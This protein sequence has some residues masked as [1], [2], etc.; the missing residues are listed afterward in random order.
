M[1]TPAPVTAYALKSAGVGNERSARFVLAMITPDL[2]DE[3]PLH[4]RRLYKY[5]T[6][7]N[8][9]HIQGQLV[10]ERSCGR[11][12]FGLCR[13]KIRF[14]AVS[15]GEA[16][17][18]GGSLVLVDQAAEEALTPDSVGL[19]V[20]D[21]GRGGR[22]GAVRGQLLPGLVGTVPVVVP[23]VFGQGCASVGLVVDQHA[24]EELSAESAHDSLSQIAFALGACGG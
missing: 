5:L 23:E 10:S 8:G 14:G 24:V 1:V 9:E 6:A 17:R 7:L 21:G 12:I 4:T 16:V 22:F 13:S 18:S 19:E 15:C 3:S 2:R 11:P 20:G